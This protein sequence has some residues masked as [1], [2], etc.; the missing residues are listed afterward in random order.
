LAAANTSSARSRRPAARGGLGQRDD[1]HPLVGAQALGGGDQPVQP[2][3]GGLQVGHQGHGDL[4]RMAKSL[5][6]EFGRN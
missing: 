3:G 4:G 2:A 1:G 5:P 6:P